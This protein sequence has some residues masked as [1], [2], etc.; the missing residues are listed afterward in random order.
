M[1]RVRILT[2]GIWAL[3]LLAP[4]ARADPI[5]QPPSADAY[6]NIGA[7]PYPEESTITTGGDPAMVR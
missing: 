2:V 4:A 6:V 7:G 3:A 1:A 5:V